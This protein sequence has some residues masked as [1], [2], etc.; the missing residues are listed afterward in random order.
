PSG[1][2][3]PYTYL[4]NT[5]DTTKDLVN[6][7]PGL[8]S[9]TVTDSTGCRN[10]YNDIELKANTIFDIGIINKKDPGCFDGKNGKISLFVSGGIP[11]YTYKWSTGDTLSTTENLKSGDYYCTITDKNLCYQVYGP[12]VLKNPEPLTSIILAKDNVTCEGEENGLIEIKTTGGTPPYSF[13]WTNERGDY[14]N[15]ND[16]IYNLK[17]GIYSLSIVDSKGCHK[18]LDSIEI[19]T[20]DSFKLITDSINHVK[21]SGSNDGYIQVSGANGYGNYYYYWNNGESLTN[22]IDSL[23]AGTYSVTATDDLGCKAIL[24]NIEVQN[25]NI[26]VDVNISLLDSLRCYGDSNASLIATVNSQHS[27][28]DYNWSAGS[29]RI[30]IHSQDTLTGLGAGFFNVTVTD[31]KGCIGT[32]E[33]IEIIQP[34]QI[35]I[36]DVDVDEILCFDDNNGR[37]SL[38]ITGGVPEYNVFWNDS[39]HIGEEIIKLKAGTY[40]CTITDQN[41]CKIE[42]NDIILNQ[43]DDISVTII[44]NPAHKNYADGS[45]KLLIQGGVSPYEIDWGA[46][47]NNQ[48]GNE[49]INLSSGGYDVTITDFNGCTKIIKVYITEIDGINNINDKQISV[50]PN[51]G[52]NFIYISGINLKSPYFELISISGISNKIKS[53]KLNSGIYKIDISNLPAGSYFLRITAAGFTSYKNITIIH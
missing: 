30:K 4:W 31:N 34:S 48:T 17:A 5:L 3:Q 42:S 19:E 53:E 35:Q 47:A 10:I 14:L 16:D 24:D 37:I 28:Y 8:Y 26:P 15:F 52:Y 11:P 44:S 40:R 6:A 2:I 45:A 49:A 51:P 21:C 20:I 7:G 13:I 32:S 23:F 36:T 46:N 29:K 9:V 25:L 38:D 22:N 41:N 39:M 18:N 12:I 50:Y 27:P 1:G 33:D 43:P